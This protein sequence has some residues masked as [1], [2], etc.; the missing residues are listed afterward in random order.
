MP[1]SNFVDFIHCASRI[2]LGQNVK[3]VV[4]RWRQ[5]CPF[6]T[7]IFTLNAPIFTNE[8]SMFKLAIEICFEN[9]FGLIHVIFLSLGLTKSVCFFYGHPV[10]FA[11]FLKT[12]PCL[13]EIYRKWDPYLK[14][15]GPK[16][17]LIF[18]AHTRTSIYDVPPPPGPV[19]ECLQLA[20]E[21]LNQK[22][23][24]ITISPLL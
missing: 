13:M 9:H 18:A 21:P 11:Y 19:A 16:K 23:N 3:A 10:L 1:S 20:V 5:I 14:N 6:K 24:S 2:C 8:V 15:S 22:E 17:P 7:N 4:W 12:Y